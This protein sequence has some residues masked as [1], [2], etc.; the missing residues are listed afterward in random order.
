MRKRTRFATAVVVTVASAG[1]SITASNPPA[2]PDTGFPITENPPPPRVR[3]DSYDVLV[4]SQSIRMIPHFTAELEYCQPTGLDVF[5]TVGACLD[6]P[7]QITTPCGISSDVT[8]LQVD[9]VMATPDQDTKEIMIVANASASS[10]LEIR[11]D[12]GTSSIP[13]HASGLPTPTTT[14]T[15]TST[16]V[17]LAWT[18]DVAAASTLV[19]VTAGLVVRHCHVAQ[20]TYTFEGQPPTTIRVQPFLP[21]EVVLTPYGE[22]RVWRGNGKAAP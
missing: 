3:V 8:N 21:P 13:L 9:G 22:I 1:C 2:P 6:Q 12:L 16:G 15:P 19:E 17:D 5:P 10:V 14:T 7:D 11:G 20:Q 4:G 18:T